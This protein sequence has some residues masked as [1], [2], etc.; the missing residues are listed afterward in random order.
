MGILFS[1]GS[2]REKNS[3]GSRSWRRELLLGSA[4]EQVLTVGRQLVEM[5]DQMH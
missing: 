2:R 5:V 3:K 4:I 1:N